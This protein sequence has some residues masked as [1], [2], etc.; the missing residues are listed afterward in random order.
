MSGS[1][2]YMYHMQAR[3][4]MLNPLG[5]EVTEDSEL[6]LRCWESNPGPSEEQLVLLTT[7]PSLPVFIL[8]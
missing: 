6:P 5:T 1:F 4:G 3:G 7:E 8:K 2:A